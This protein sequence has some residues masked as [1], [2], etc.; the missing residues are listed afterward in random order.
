MCSSEGDRIRVLRSSISALRSRFSTLR[1][2]SAGAESL[3]EFLLESLLASLLASL[4]ESLLAALLASL[5]E[6]LLESLLGSLDES[7]LGDSQSRLGTRHHSFGNVARSCGISEK[8]RR[9]CLSYRGPA[10]CETT[11]R[12]SERTYRGWHSADPA[13]DHCAQLLAKRAHRHVVYFL[14]LGCRI[15]PLY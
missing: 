15:H 13:P 7:G 14:Y 9:E 6:S 8:L 10:L 11:G 4:L 2:D 1:R 12:I 5:F 3:L